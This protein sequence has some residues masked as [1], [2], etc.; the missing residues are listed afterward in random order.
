M[1]DLLNEIWQTIRTNKLRTVLTGIAVSWGVFMLIVLLSMARGLINKFD[2]D[3][4]SRNTAT[5]TVYGGNTSIPYNGHPEGRSIQLEE[6]DMSSIKDNDRTHV[7]GVTSRI[8]GGGVITSLKGRVNQEY[9]GVFPSI[10]KES[11][12]G[13]ITEGRFINARDVEHRA[14]VMVIPQY[15]AA[16]LFP[17]EGND[18]VGKRVE[19]QGLSFKVIGVFESRWNRSFYIPYTTARMLVADKKDLGRLTVSL[20]EVST[21]YDGLVAEANIR[22]TLARAHDFDPHDTNAVWIDNSFLNSVKASVAKILLNTGTW[23]LGVLT[24]L[25]GI[26]GISNIMFVTVK[27]RTHEIGIRRAIGARPIKILTQVVA[28]AVAITLLFGYLGIVSGMVLTQIIAH[29]I[30][31]DG[32]LMNPTVSIA[33]AME[34]TLFLVV[35]GALAGL[36]PAMRALKIKP[37]EALRDE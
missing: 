3:M 17:P 10:I 26:V 31:D 18:A 2:H 6:R 13:E 15:Y 14:K 22:N 9:E 34:V 30:G 35:A 33:I 1:I 28:E 23:V 16:Q 21:E 36:F 12:I 32:P 4:M 37:V 5:I 8:Y 27:E 25:T 7:D 19:C 20:K 29:F 11:N 24:L